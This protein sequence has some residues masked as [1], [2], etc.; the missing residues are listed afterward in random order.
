[1]AAVFS[2]QDVTEIE[3]KK[4]EEKQSPTLFCRAVIL[5]ALLSPTPHALPFCLLEPTV[6]SVTPVVEQASP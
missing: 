6:F 2:F 4:T 5:V 1:M 3:L